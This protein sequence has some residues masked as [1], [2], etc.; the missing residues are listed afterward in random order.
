[1]NDDCVKSQMPKSKF[2]SSN[3]IP[4][5]R[6]NSTFDNSS[7]CTF[8]SLLWTHHK[9][10]HEQLSIHGI[11]R[12][13]KYCTLYRTVRYGTFQILRYSTVLTNDV[14]YGTLVP[15][16]FQCFIS[17]ECSVPIVSLLHS[18]YCLFLLRYQNRYSRVRYGTGTF[19]R[20]C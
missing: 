19:V 15:V 16:E 8:F 12:P 20:S 9:N 1:M 2:V 5:K 3:T 13:K 10:G 14:R 4:K 11:F 17:D 6:N 18:R 7:Y